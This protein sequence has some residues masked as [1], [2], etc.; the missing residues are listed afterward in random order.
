MSKTSGLVAELE[1]LAAALTADGASAS[2]FS[3]ALVA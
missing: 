1:R 2:Q 3:F